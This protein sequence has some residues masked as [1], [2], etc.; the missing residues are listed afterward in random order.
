MGRRGPKAKPTELRVADGTYRSDRHGEVVAKPGRPD[1]PKWVEGA[2]A[3]EWDRVAGELTAMGL[4]AEVDQ[5]VLGMCCLAFA[6]WLVARGEGAVMRMERAAAQWLRLARELG[7][8]P[9][10]RCGMHKLG[11]QKPSGQVE[12]RK[13]G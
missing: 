2:A 10:A 6:D 13:R 9:S 12:R 7:L 5:T 8:T 3:A 4:L 1:R 11:N